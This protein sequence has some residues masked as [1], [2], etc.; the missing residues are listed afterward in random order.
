MLLLSW[1]LE[2]GEHFL[3]I[4]AGTFDS[5]LKPSSDMMSKHMILSKVKLLVLCS[6]EA[7]FVYTHLLPSRII[8]P[9]S[10]FLF[11]HNSFISFIIHSSS[12][13][14]PP[15]L[16]S[17]VFTCSKIICVVNSKSSSFD[18]AGD[19]PYPTNTLLSLACSV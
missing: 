16:L 19:P 5:K 3:D 4:Y 10:S 12:T 18:L 8:K 14:P 1:Y 2:T 13:T 6:F 9:S 11:S 7:I 15:S 17:I